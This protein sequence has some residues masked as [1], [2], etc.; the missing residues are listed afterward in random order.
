MLRIAR[1]TIAFG[2][3]DR[4]ASM[5]IVLFVIVLEA[6]KSAIFDIDGA[7]KNRL[8]G[9]FFSLIAITTM[10]KIRERHYNV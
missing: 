3:I 5:F 10:V 1:F 4:C 7:G 9:F 6:N 2:T 8:G